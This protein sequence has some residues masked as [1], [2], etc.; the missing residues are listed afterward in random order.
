VVVEDGHEVWHIDLD[1]VQDIRAVMSKSNAQDIQAEMAAEINDL[2]DEITLL[3]SQL[4][5]KDKQISE[6]HV[7]L[8]VTQPKQLEEAGKR[9][10]WMFWRR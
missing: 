6:L 7:L 3:K 1:N 8:A 4:T 2:K 5:E 10:W 9:R